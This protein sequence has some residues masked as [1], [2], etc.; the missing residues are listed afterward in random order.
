MNGTM[1]MIGRLAATLVVALLL[2]TMLVEEASAERVTKAKAGASIKERVKTQQEVCEILDGGT[3]SSQ[4]TAFGSTITKCTGG[5]GGDWS[6]VNTKKST[7]CTYQ[8]K[9]LTQ[10]TRT[11]L[12]G[13]A[14]PLSEVGAANEPAGGFTRAGEAA[15]PTSDLD[16]AQGEAAASGLGSRVEALEGQA[17]VAAEVAPDDDWGTEGNAAPAGGGRLG[18]VRAKD[19]GM[20]LADD[21]ER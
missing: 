6:C 16:A 15:A 8:D 18:E 5:D 21:D 10:P 17:I 7:T 2:G 11:R 4:K 20:V 9:A 1:R 14:A 3:F 13:V 12:D 19:G